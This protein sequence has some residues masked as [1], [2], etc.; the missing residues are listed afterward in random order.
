MLPNDDEEGKGV[1]DW[2]GGKDPAVPAAAAPPPTE[3]EVVAVMLADDNDIDDEDGDDEEISANFAFEDLKNPE[4]DL[5]KEAL[6]LFGG[7]V[8]REAASAMEI[9]TGEAPPLE[10]LP[11]K[12]EAS[13]DPRCS[14]I[15]E[16]GVAARSE[17]P[18]WG[19]ALSEALAW[20]VG[21]DM[22]PTPTPRLPKTSCSTA[23]E[24]STACGPSRPFSQYKNT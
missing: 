2:R 15:C 22:F 20:L 17:G 8:N 4:M 24:Y 3:D 5:E 7:G 18:L 21:A 14:G 6:L 9:G 13:V 1:E 19:C 23:G 16:E 10:A 11:A 12:T